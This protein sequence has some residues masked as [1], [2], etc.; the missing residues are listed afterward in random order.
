MKDPPKILIVCL[1][2]F[3]NNGSKNNASVKFPFRLELDGHVLNP[4]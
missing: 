4:G 3:N 1:K 2:R